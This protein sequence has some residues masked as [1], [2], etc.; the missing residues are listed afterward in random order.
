MGALEVLLNQDPEAAV[1]VLDA[2]LVTRGP[3]RGAG[4][5]N[6]D[7]NSMFLER[8]SYI[9]RRTRLQRVGKHLS[10]SEGH[11]LLDLPAARQ[12]R[13]LGLAQAQPQPPAMKTQFQ[14]SLRAA[15]GV[16][17]GRQTAT[18]SAPSGVL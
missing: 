13:D 7:L 15:S 6:S 14:E 3:A 4:A 2:G 8:S 16:K 5:G 17:A 1:G 11:R 10:R 18:Y 9:R 12:P